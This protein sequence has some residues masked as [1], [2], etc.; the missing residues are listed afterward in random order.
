MKKSVDAE[1][2]LLWY[3]FVGYKIHTSQHLLSS[4][5]GCLALDIRGLMKDI[6]LEMMPPMEVTSPL[7]PL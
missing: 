5:E 7:T 1:R 2:L 4:K 3:P 6:R